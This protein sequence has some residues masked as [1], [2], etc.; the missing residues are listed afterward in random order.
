MIRHP[1]MAIG[2]VERALAINRRFFSADNVLISNCLRLLA[3]LHSKLG[4]GNVDAAERAVAETTA[5]RRSQTQCA[6]AGCPRKMKADGS[7]LEM[8]SGCRQTHYCSVE[9]QRADWKAVHKAEC[10]QLLQQLQQRQRA[11]SS[12]STASASANPSS[13]ASGGSR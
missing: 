13:S 10:K 5:A 12:A 6:A 7:P 1:L 2:L 3:D 9:C 4:P 11:S 8:C